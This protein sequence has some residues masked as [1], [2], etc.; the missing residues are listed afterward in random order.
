L[1]Y[2]WFYAIIGRETRLVGSGLSQRLFMS[3]NAPPS[4]A[5]SLGARFNNFEY[6]FTHGS[7]LALPDSSS[8]T[9]VEARIPAKYMA[10]HRFALKPSWGEIAFWEGVIYSGRNIDLA[11]LNPL[12]FM[13]SLEHALHDRDNS[14]M[15]GDLTLRPLAGLQLKAS[16]LLDDVVFSE[17]GKSYWS[18][19]SAWNAAVIASLPGAIDLGIEYSRIE[20]YTFSH[21][22]QKNSVTSDSLI[23][24]SYLLPN[25]DETSILM[26]WWW[27][28]RYPLEA[29]L[30]YMRHGKN[31]YDTN[32]NL[33]K[34][35]GGD[36]LLVRRSEDPF[37]VSF[38]DGEREDI[39][40][41]SIQTGWEI[42]RGF[43]LHGIYTYRNI[44]GVSYNSIRVLFRFEDF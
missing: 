5:L 25:S 37:T 41:A 27:G 43:N 39:F 35:V 38:L 12:S 17:I 40:S 14:M 15:G 29:R 22:N 31:I 3:S 21:F 6:R 13:K 1:Q 11:Y 18:N 19:K 30:S 4:D 10:T 44:D 28:G 9:G 36:P 20:P 34:N 8:E 16:Y 2:D 32:G 33:I 26:Q 42:I 7:L 23:V 24:G